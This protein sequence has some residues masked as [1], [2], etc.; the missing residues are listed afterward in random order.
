[1]NSQCFLGRLHSQL[2]VSV[3]SVGVQACERA[4]GCTHWK[5][6]VSRGERRRAEAPAVPAALL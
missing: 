6:V 4:P 3:A 2:P 1:M 5:R